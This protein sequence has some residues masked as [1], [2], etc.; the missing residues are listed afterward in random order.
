MRQLGLTHNE[1]QQARASERNVMDHPHI[2]LMTWLN[3]TGKAATVDFLLE[4]LDKIHQ[5]AARE[6]ILDKLISSRL[7]DYQKRED[8]KPN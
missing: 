6:I 3:K 5:K 8:E 2:L 1:I 4:T 7:Y